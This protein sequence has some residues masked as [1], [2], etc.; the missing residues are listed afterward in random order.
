MVWKTCQVVY[1][2]LTGFKLITILRQ[3][4]DGDRYIFCHRY[5]ITCG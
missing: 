2:L 1:V 5:G 4:P 3:L